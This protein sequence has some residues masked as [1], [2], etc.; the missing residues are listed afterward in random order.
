[1]QTELIQAQ[2]L[3]PLVA[4]VGGIT[5]AIIAIIAK[6]IRATA[7]TKEVEATRRE[8]AAYVAEGSITPADAERLLKASSKTESEC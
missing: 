8:I 1:M 6:T 5:V 3:I 2:D 4:I 7:R